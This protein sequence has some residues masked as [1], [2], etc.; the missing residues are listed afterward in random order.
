MKDIAIIRLQKSPDV[1]GADG[2]LHQNRYTSM[3]QMG[4]SPKIVTGV[5]KLAQ[6]VTKLLLTTQGSDIYDPDYGSGLLYLL[7]QAQSPSDLAALRGS[8]ATHVSD[9]R[10]QVI[11]SQVNLALPSD[12]RLQDLK[13]LSVDFDQV[14][15]KF[16]IEV[17]LVSEAGNSRTLNIQNLIAE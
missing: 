5:H 15:M 14:N 4:I 8:I 10:T 9:V 6:F 2:A 16:A 7:R 1:V 12:E 13:L 3:P 17:A 11:A